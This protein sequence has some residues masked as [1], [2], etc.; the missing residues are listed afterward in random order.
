MTTDVPARR[1]ATLIAG[2]PRHTIRCY[3][4]E[5]PC[6]L[7]KDV[8]AALEAAEAEAVPM[9]HKLQAMHRRAQKAEG[10]LSRAGYI[11]VAVQGYLKATKSTAPWY[12]LHNLI[13]DALGYARRGSARAMWAD[14]HWYSAEQKAATARADAAE[15]KLARVRKA[16]PV[17]R[18]ASGSGGELATAIEEIDA[19][20]DGKA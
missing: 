7:E 3:V 13:G 14:C 8:L 19:A 20:L 5:L 17:V 1:F 4:D 16:W 11:L 15:A 6:L 9:R 10:L 12:L 2:V 18:D